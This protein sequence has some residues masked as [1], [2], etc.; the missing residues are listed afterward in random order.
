MSRSIR[1]ILGITLLLGLVMPLRGSSHREAP[2]ISEDPV[3]DNTD[4]YVFVS[5]DKPDT[6][7]IVANFIPLEEPAGGP[8]F[9]KFG[10]EVTYYIVIDNDGNGRGDIEYRFDFNTRVQNPNTFLYDTG[11]ITALD[12][13]DFNV[14]QFYSV[15]RVQNNLVTT[16]GSNLATPPVNVGTRSTGNTAGN[17]QSLAQDAVHTLPDGSLV[18]AGQRDDPFYVDLG[19]VFDLLG[20]RPFN[21]AHRIPLAAARG[22]DGLG[23]F[24]VH[25]I[26]LQ[27]PKERLTHDGSPGTDP[28]NTNSIIG[29]Y[30]RTTRP[31]VK[32]L[33]PSGG[34]PAFSSDRVQVSRLA[35]PL[36]NE[37]IIP[38]AR[39]DRWNSSRPFDDAQFLGFVLDPE[40]ARLIALL[41]PGITVPAPPR[42]DLV[43]IFLTGISGLNQPRNVAPAEMLR[44][45]MAIEPS[46][47]PSRLGLLAGQRDGFPNG[48]RLVDDVVDIELRA[49]AGGTPFTPA[50]NRTPNNALA[51]GVN[52]NDKAFLSAFPYVPRPHGGDLHIHHP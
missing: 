1:L 29:V 20:L 7:T 6:V 46:A 26:A 14:R 35:S 47:N 22:V 36:I 2:L 9:Y 39:K 17:Y 25:T 4:V 41:Y 13:P 27:I 10:D 12:D 34:P 49:L 48:R 50:F 32:S 37:V 45:N 24:N 8:N 44:L 15:R 52:A 40:P 3:A 5:P 21:P 28:N 11:R 33:S 23:G 19:S 30:S 18:F 31:R 42:N 51:D 38:L 43:A 16:L